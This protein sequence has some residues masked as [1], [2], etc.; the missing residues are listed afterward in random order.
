M[1][2]RLPLHA[3]AVSSVSPRDD[4]CSG[5]AEGRHREEGSGVAHLICPLTNYSKRGMW[6]CNASVTDPWIDKGG[7]GTAKGAAEGS[8]AVFARRWRTTATWPLWAAARRGQRNGLD[9]SPLWN[10]GGG[11]SMSQ[12]GY[13]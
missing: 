3:A 4:R 1:V 7:R 12:P 9:G 13:R 5:S 6:K 8:P 11:G 10:G 2:G